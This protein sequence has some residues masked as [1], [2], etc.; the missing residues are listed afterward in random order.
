MSCRVSSTED[1]AECHLPRHVSDQDLGPGSVITQVQ[2]QRDVVGRKDRD[3]SQGS[4]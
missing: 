1:L 3:P 4:G 2:V